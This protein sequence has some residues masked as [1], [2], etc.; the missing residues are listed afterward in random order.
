MTLI[1]WSLRVKASNRIDAINQIERASLP[2]FA[3]QYLVGLV[4]G[5]AYVTMGRV[6][7]DNP[8]CVWGS[9][10]DHGAYIS[11]D[12]GGLAYRKAA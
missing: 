1:R 12:S 4:E 6:N 7:P 10:E 3:E 11:I 8:L 2:L 5:E 9:G